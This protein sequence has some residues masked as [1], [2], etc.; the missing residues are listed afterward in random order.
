[1]VLLTVGSK[2]QARIRPTNRPPLPRRYLEQQ[3]CVL[4]AVQG[5]LSPAWHSRGS[6]LRVDRRSV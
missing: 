2:A 6:G 3:G 5:F 1:M 4:L